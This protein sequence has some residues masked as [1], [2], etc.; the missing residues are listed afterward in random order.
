MMKSAAVG[1]VDET[2]LRNSILGNSDPVVKWAAT[3]L[4]SGVTLKE[5]PWLSFFLRTTRA[6]VAA[7]AHQRW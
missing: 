2:K 4:L 3:R 6:G 7:R 1:L 5:A